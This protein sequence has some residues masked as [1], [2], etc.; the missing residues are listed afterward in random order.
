MTQIQS[1]YYPHTHSAKHTDF[2]KYSKQKHKSSANVK[3]VLKTDTNIPSVDKISRVTNKTQVVSYIEDTTYI[4]YISQLVIYLISQVVIYR[5]WFTCEW[6]FLSV[7]HLAWIRAWSILN[8]PDFTKL[9][10]LSCISLLSW[11]NK[12]TLTSYSWNITVP[13]HQNSQNTVKMRKRFIGLNLF[14]T[15]HVIAFFTFT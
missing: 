8:F 12:T 3:R 9:M 2:K 6:E 4:I 15:S 5:R 1:D 7:P 13:Q 14:S 11:K 10:R